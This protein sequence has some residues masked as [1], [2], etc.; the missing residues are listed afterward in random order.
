MLTESTHYVFH[1]DEN[2]YAE[3]NIDHIIQTQEACYEYICSVLH[4]T[5][6]FKIHYYLCDTPEMVGK[7]YGDLHGDEEYEPC[8]GFANI[9]NEIYAVYNEKVQCIGFH[10]DAHL[11]SYLINRPTSGFIREGL[12]MFFDQKWWS[13][14]NLEWVQY[15]LSKDMVLSITEYLRDDIFY[16][17]DCTITYPI[18]GFFTEYLIL[19]YG[20][21]KYIKMYSYV[22]KIQDAFQYAYGLESDEIDIR[23]KKYLQLFKVD[24]IVMKRIE[25]L[26]SE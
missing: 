11:I 25:I 20:I 22:G 23:F 7:Y 19:T 3:K 4:V 26:L 5:P 8:N 17:H 2:S 16:E 1:Y 10:E 21:E 14:S 9:P 6:D 24:P 13:I 18:A 12:A 15:Y